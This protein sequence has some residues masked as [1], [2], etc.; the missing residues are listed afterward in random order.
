MS[1]VETQKGENPF[2]PT[3]GWLKTEVTNSRRESLYLKCEMGVGVV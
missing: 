1:R 2:V 3:N